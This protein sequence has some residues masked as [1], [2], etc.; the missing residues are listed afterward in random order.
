MNEEPEI[1]EH[2]T[3]TNCARFFE[4]I[5]VSTYFDILHQISSDSP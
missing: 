1:V 5:E 3:T 4:N 2:N